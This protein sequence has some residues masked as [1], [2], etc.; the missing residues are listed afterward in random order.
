MTPVILV[1]MV[2]LQG[3]PEPV[4]RRS[5]VTNLEECVERGR[6]FVRSS[7]PDNLRVEALSFSCIIL[8]GSTS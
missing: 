8:Q 5:V 2:I 4:S 6:T 3:N 7:P 1:L